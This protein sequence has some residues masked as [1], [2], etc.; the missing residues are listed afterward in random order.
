MNLHFGQYMP[1]I[2]LVNMGYNDFGYGVK[3]SKGK[4][5]SL[6]KKDLM[7][8]EDAYHF[9]LEELNMIYPE[10]EIVCGTLMR[11]KMVGNIRW[12]FPETFGGVPFDQYNDVIRKACKKQKCHLADINRLNICYETLDG[13][14]PTINGHLTIAD[15]WVEALR[16]IGML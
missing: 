15:A 11:T 8:F 2:I 12:I 5:H 16:D 7:Y 1:N 14:H 10:A 13:S 6:R 3:I 4:W 9:L